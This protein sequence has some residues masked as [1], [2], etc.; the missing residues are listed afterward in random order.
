MW[1]TSDLAFGCRRAESQAST[2]K[3][4]AKH[5]SILNN[6]KSFQTFPTPNPGAEVRVSIAV[7]TA[8]TSRRLSEDAGE[9]MASAAA[10]RLQRALLTGALGALG[11]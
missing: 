2:K 11:L 1:L 8:S 9:S 5:P 7:P 4:D 10:K 6:Q 3:L